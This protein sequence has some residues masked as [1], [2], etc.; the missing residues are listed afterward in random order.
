MSC[1]SQESQEK[2]YDEY[3]GKKV[4]DG[5]KYYEDLKSDKTINFLTSNDSLT[6][7]ILNKIPNQEKL[8]KLQ[9]IING[10][11]SRNSYSNILHDKSGN[12][13]YLKRKD[14][15]D[16][17][18]LYRKNLSDE[19][20]LIFDPEELNENDSNY[21][22]NYHKP[23]WNGKYIAISLTKNGEE[24]SFIKVFDIDNEEFLNVK[25]NN[26]IPS[27]GGI[28]WLPDNSG[29]TFFKLPFANN[30]KEA[31]LNTEGVLFDLK[32][33]SEKTLISKR[34]N[35]E[36]AIEEKDL[37][38]VIF[39]RPND[40]YIVGAVAGPTPYYDTYYKDLD[41]KT[42]KWK[43]LFKK[44]EQVK[45]YYQK[46]DTLYYL[47][48]K[49][50]PN[51]R[52]C[53]TSIINP[54]YDNPITIVKESDSE[55]IQG[56]RLINNGI[57]YSTTKNGVIAN[58]YFKSD[59]IEKIDLPFQAGD[60]I[61]RSN[62]NDKELLLSAEGWLSK[63]RRF[64]Y[65][66]SK[67]TFE[68][69]EIEIPEVFP[70]SLKNQ[71]I[72]EELTVRSHDGVEV[73]L[74]LIYKKGLKKDK[75]NSVFMIA[76]GAYG[77]SIEPGFSSKILTWALEGGIFAV[78]HV[79]GGGEKGDSW[80]KDGYK[81]R[82]PNSW[83]DLIACANHLIDIKYTKAK[84]IA[85]HGASAGGI[86]VGR[87]MTEKPE[88]FGAVISSMG[89]LNTLR[90][91]EGYNGENNSK[92]FG[93]KLTKDGFESLLA[94]DAFHSIKE[95]AVYPAT[96]IEI[97]MNDSRVPPWHSIKFAAKLKENNPNTPVFLDVDFKSG[98]SFD[99]S[100]NQRLSN[101]ARILA[102]AFW[103]T[104]HIDYQFSE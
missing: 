16:I 4:Y 52:L 58:L 75:E 28:N 37:C 12:K 77:S 104:G 73:P 20:T 46:G 97:G 93:S 99:N 102:F 88:L 29:F 68:S 85:I 14:N 7:S 38:A 41:T 19:E 21:V 67:K 42:V 44:E 18:K 27:V 31:Y 33:K 40:K 53:K 15:E 50:S 54:D 39:D 65:N 55:V 3:F 43:T 49:D 45:S 83:K 5:Y 96:L 95:E 103:Q 89:F 71:L 69:A 84:K 82:K 51:F 98:H 94:M 78:A 86:T 9:E 17:Y 81:L 66:F 30:S 47:T 1:N 26:C 61:V 57:A 8:I 80:Y 76:Y 92:E 32:S 79:R 64:T 10:G 56:F 87:A 101:V 22:I 62:W 100:K 70:D 13:F 72:V 59:K 23:S 91:E 90:I 74:S 2:H 25:V 63:E 6:E 34:N 35:P 24:F 11:E 48:S 60:I 36:L